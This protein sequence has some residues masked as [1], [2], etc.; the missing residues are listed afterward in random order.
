MGK[1]KKKITDWAEYNKARCKRGSVKF[2]IDD[3]AIDA[4]QCKTHH[5]QRGRCFQYSNT[6]IEITLM[7]RGNSPCHYVQCRASLTLFSSYL[8][9]PLMSPDYT[10]LSKRS[11]T[12]QVKYRNKSRGAIRH[13]VIDSA[14]LKVR[15]E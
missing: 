12:V 10:C 13:I 8:D 15:G 6:A 1:A 7:I 3:S 14:G 2:W 9:V 5:G 4:W 11:K